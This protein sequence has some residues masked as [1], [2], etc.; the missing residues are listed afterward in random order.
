[1]STLRIRILDG[2]SAIL[3]KDFTAL[4]SGSARTDPGTGATVYKLK[5]AKDAA[6]TNQLAKFVFVSGKGKLTL[7]L[8]RLD[9]SVV[10]PTEAHLGIELTVGDRIYYTAVTLFEKRVGSFTTA[11]PAG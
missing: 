4:G 2:A 1:V 3:D 9:L 8:A 5:A 10:P 7:N 11:M 6:D